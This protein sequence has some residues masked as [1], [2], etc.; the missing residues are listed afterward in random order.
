MGGGSYVPITA[1]MFE[2]LSSARVQIVLI[3]AHFRCACWCDRQDQAGIFTDVAVD[4]RLSGLVEAW[5][6]GTDWEQLMQDTSLDEG[7]VVRVLRRTADF[8]AQVK[9]VAGLPETLVG[10]ARA[11]SKLVDRP[12][13][14]DL[15]LS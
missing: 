10:N 2:V 7:D 3:G 6:C 1:Y 8:L 13:I 12:P 11:A 5:A 4:L 14:A 9:L 15:T